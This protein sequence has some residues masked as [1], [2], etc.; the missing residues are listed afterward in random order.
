[1]DFY[2]SEAAISQVLYER[3]GSAHVKHVFEPVGY[4]ALTT[5]LRGH[6]SLLK[7]Q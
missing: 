6:R 5:D 1:M 2:V 3:F 7:S 4:P